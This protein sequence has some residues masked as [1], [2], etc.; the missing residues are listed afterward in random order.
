VRGISFPDAQGVVLLFG[1]LLSFGN[2]FLS[3]Y[4]IL[5]G[6]LRD[7]WDERIE[8]TGTQGRLEVRTPTWNHVDSKASLLRHYDNRSGNLQEYRFHA[9][10]PFDRAIAFFCANIAKGEQGDQ[11]RWTGYEADE[12]IDHIKQSAASGQAVA[13]KWKQGT[14]TAQ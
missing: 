1:A 8:I 6:F 12:L 14:I 4:G 10:S 11:S 9:E 13:I 2:L 5:R 7:G 3:L